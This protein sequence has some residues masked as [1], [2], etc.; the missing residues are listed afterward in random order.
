MIMT[1]VHHEP[2]F[3]GLEAAMPQC[4]CGSM[5]SVI[6]P[7]KEFAQEILTSRALSTFHTGSLFRTK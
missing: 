4:R 1:G 2:V 5:T 7:S 6:P 3:E